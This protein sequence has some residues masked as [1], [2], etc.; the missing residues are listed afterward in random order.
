[1]PA[2][3]DRVTTRPWARVV[4]RLR[5]FVLRGTGDAGTTLAEVLV[6]LAVIG[7]VMAATAPFMVNSVILVAEQRSKQAAVQVA[8]DAVE[9]VRALAP[10]S[11]L[12]GR[13]KMATDA[14]WSAAPAK[15]ATALADTQADWDP[16]LPLAAP[17]G[18]QAPLPTAP[19]TVNLANVA[20]AQQWYVGRCW[21]TK[22]AAGSA[23]GAAADCKK[24]HTSAD[25]PYFRVVVSV[26][27]T[28]K[29]CATGPCVYVTSTL[30]SIGG[31][32]HFDLNR[33]PPSITG[34]SVMTVY[35]GD[36]LTT[37]VPADPALQMKSTGGSMPLDWQVTGVLPPGLTLVPQSGKLEG[38]ATTPGTKSVQV[39]VTDRV[40]DSDIATLTVEVFN[41]LALTKPADQTSDLGTALSL[42]LVATGGKPAL[43]YS[44]TTLPAGLTLN[45][46]T[47]VI[48]GTPTTAQ[49]PQPVT[50]TVTDANNKSVSQTFNWEIVVPLAVTSTAS[51]T[52]VI[53][54]ILGG[55]TAI[56]MT[57]SGGT[58][59]YTWRAD[60]LPTGL[61]IDPNTGLI[62]GTATSG[63]RF[64]TTV[65]ITDNTGRVASAPVV[66]LLTNDQPSNLQVSVPDPANPNQT[67][68]VNTTV[69]LTAKTTGGSG[70]QT[71]T[72][73]GLPTGL[74]M[75][76]GGVISGKPTVKGTYLVRL[77]VADNSGRTAALMFTWTVK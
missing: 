26:T 47:G 15:V 65:Y 10:A 3:W 76:S 60:D 24:T 5:R 40:G 13:G 70:Q 35:V 30:A 62:T 8:N 50:V 39:T 17:D 61:S 4:R 63:T 73:T 57:G 23:T 43:T 72:A 55:A 33:P 19:V 14:Q 46:T 59:A 44:S 32:P 2:S 58:G 25:L 31:D 16:M 34:P 27:W 29:G 38:T 18:A 74:T 71:W 7:T 48:S 69:S 53:N 22:T 6:A 68:T 1:M 12:T 64:V 52:L 21:Q 41:K 42:Q 20:Y 11:L 51:Q 37:A 66:W 75:S 67:T 54:T 49:A 45:T 9:R 36:N 77:N 28:G 56:P